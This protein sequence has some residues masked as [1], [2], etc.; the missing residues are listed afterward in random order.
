MKIRLFIIFLSLINLPLL[1]Q[2]KKE[3]FFINHSFEQT[4][5][6]TA[7]PM[8]WFSGAE[9]GL[10]FEADSSHSTEG[11]RSLLVRSTQPMQRWGA[12]SFLRM[13]DY[14]LPEPVKTITIQMDIKSDS[15][16]EGYFSPFIWKQHNNGQIVVKNLADD[17]LKA[18]H[19]WK[20]YAVSDTVG[21]HIDQAKI[22]AGIQLN[23]KGQ[24][25][26][27]NVQLFINGKEIKDT[28]FNPPTPSSEDLTFIKEHSI[29]F[30]HVDPYA[31]LND[32][33]FL[34]NKIEE[35]QIIGLGEA[36]HGT[37]EIFTMKHRLIRYLAEKHGFTTFLME[38]NAGSSY[39]INKYLHSGIG[40]PVELVQNI[41]FW[42]WT[43][44][45]VLEMVR[46]M[47]QYN[48]SAEPDNQL[49]FIGVDIQGLV[50]EIDIIDSLTRPLRVLNIDLMKHYSPIQR[51]GKKY[52]NR[53]F[54]KGFRDSLRATSTKAKNALMSIEKNKSKIIQQTD[55]LQYHWIYYM[56]KNVTNSVS[57][58]NEMF[59]LS[60]GEPY[61]KGRDSL[62]V[63]NMQYAKKHLQTG[64]A[65]YWAH[66][67]HIAKEVH[68]ALGK[69]AGWRLNKVYGSAYQ[70][71]AF[72]FYRGTYRAMNGRKG[73][74]TT[75]NIAYPPYPGCFEYLL[76][77][78]NRTPLFFDIQSS[79][80][81][82]PEFYKKQTFRIRRLGAF[83][84]DNQFTEERIDKHFDY[85]IYLGETRAAK[86]L[87]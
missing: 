2:Q 43:T 18:S 50:E 87:K 12:M 52:K 46:W 23:G 31:S 75:K 42:T 79:L 51:I 21:V 1:A 13:V 59:N 77:R 33:S 85:L 39:R 5:P 80:T 29:P 48:Q 41:G 65:I 76:Q 19:D 66:N 81:S 36:T 9:Y 8:Q 63:E 84:S 40:D 26:A 44:E 57:Y 24:L 47:R 54:F 37:S 70:A 22:F 35:A 56:A 30:E 68:A 17:S 16:S 67:G 61:P 45:E 32:L 71:I 10:F 60:P 69:M 74:L 62:M 64:K 11:N 73:K 78:Q 82:N 7:I 6:E 3:A 83:A 25:W 27:D 53:E 28:G 34:D 15:V 86:E 58:L 20:R 49:S 14:D 55:S 38:G 72:S 4:Y